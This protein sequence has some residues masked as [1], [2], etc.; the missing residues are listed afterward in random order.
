M[1]LVV[2]KPP[3]SIWDIQNWAK[4]LIHSLEGYDEITVIVTRATS[5]TVE[6]VF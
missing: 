1:T 5:M 2:T 4:C 3:S 6:R